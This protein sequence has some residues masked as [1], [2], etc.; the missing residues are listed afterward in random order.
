M[1]DLIIEGIPKGKTPS[2]EFKA[3]GQLMISGRSIPED[4]NKFYE[5]VF[6]WFNSF[7]T[8]LPSNVEMRVSLEYFNTSS[9][10]HLLKLFNS[11]V[12][13]HLD[14]KTEVKIIW[15]FQENDDDMREAGRDYKSIV[16]VPF[17]MIQVI[18]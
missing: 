11:L 4:T 18:N 3:S 16:R 17:E 15:Y 6:S 14:K 13:L 8:N 1:D 7:K 2:I 5:P 12:T 10:I 9:S